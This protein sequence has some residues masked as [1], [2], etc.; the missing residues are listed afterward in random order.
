[1]A[2]SARARMH[3]VIRGRVQGIGF[4]FAA[5]DEASAMGLTGWVR[6]RP[7]GEVEI[8]AE[9]RRETL[10]MLAKWANS[11]PRMARVESVAEEWSE[12]ADEFA[13]FRI[14]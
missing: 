13:D 8:I 10:Q 14:R 9:G 11:G 1:M 5:S 3:L 4:R 7:G 12:F 2:D 6:N